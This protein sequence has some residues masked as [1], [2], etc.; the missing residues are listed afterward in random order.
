MNYITINGA[1][2]LE[3]E[4]AR[5]FI[6]KLDEMSK[7]LREELHDKGFTIRYNAGSTQTK[8]YA[9]WR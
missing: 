1:I 6:K 7:E 5:E 3:G 4:A 8:L 9:Y 2:K